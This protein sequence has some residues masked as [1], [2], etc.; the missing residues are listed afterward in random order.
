MTNLD[1][2]KA[3]FEKK[4]DA[5]RAAHDSQLQQELGE[6]RASLLSEF[7][8]PKPQ[9]VFRQAEGLGTDW[10]APQVPTQKLVDL[11]SSNQL[12]A[13]DA[14]FIQLFNLQNWFPVNRLNY[15]TVYCE[16]LSEFFSPLVKSMALSPEARQAELQAL[17]AEAEAGAR[18]HGGGIFGFNLPGDG[19]YLN[20]WLFTCRSKMAPRQA[21]EHPELL[22]QILKTAV[23][24]KLG[25]G[26]LAAYS[27]LGQVKTRLG[28]GQIEIAQRFG[29]RSSDDPTSSLRMQQANLIFSVSQFVEEGWATWLA[30]YMASQTLQ[31]G[32]YQGYHLQGVVDAI[33]ALPAELPERVDI[34]NSLLRAIL[35]LFGDDQVSLQQLQRAMLVMEI[36]GSPLDD[37]FMGRLGQ[38]LRY[39]I[40]ELVFVQ[41]ENNLGSGCLPYAALIAANVSFDPASLGLADLRE[42]L[43]GDAR[44][45]PDA[46]LAALSRL[47]LQEKNNV[48]GLVRQ[49]AAELSIS[50]PSELKR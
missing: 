23:H 41:A 13:L 14:A 46:R 1:D 10:H 32:Q 3:S 18:K 6:L 7:K 22:R 30:N 38:P 9:E 16:S 33:K 45:H 20:G 35:C 50:I 8:S 36:I 26:F 49:A 31:A 42:L 12:Q 28:L 17:V 4:L 48:Q 27:A 25:H 39:V 5:Q 37:Y 2:L 29:L 24:E 19:A 44:L 15:P 47:N 43:Q 40:G 21:F 34:Q 11:G